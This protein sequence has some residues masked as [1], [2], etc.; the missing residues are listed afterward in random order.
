MNGRF[1]IA[2]HILTLLH[3]AKNELLSSDYIAGSVN[4][5]AVLIR[6]ELSNLRGAGLVS[7][8]EGKA[9]GYYLNKDAHQ[10]TMADIYNVAMQNPILGKARNQPNP[11]CPIGQKIGGHLNKLDAD[12]TLTINNKL[13]KQTLADFYKQ[14]D[15]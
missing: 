5:N 15:Q 12:I 3:A 9:G 10:I 11:K 2:V 8:K 1:Q 13:A 7:S 4:A 6:K 14:F